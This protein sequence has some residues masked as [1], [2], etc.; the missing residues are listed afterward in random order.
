MATWKKLIPACCLFQAAVAA[1][2]EEAWTYEYQ[3]KHSAVMAGREGNQNAFKP[4]EHGRH[5]EGAA[6]GAKEN[7]S[8]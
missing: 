1:L 6:L 3:A 7:D 2:P 8:C 4:G 5:V